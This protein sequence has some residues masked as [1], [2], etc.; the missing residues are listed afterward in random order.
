MVL[1]YVKAHTILGLEPFDYLE[2]PNRRSTAFL[3]STNSGGTAA[4]L[5]QLD[6]TRVSA[7][8]TACESHT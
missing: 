6:S 7:E 1:E 2:D 8:G 5:E 3:A 4:L